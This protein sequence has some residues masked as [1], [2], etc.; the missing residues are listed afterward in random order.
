MNVLFKSVIT[1]PHCGFK[2]EETMPEDAC[3]YY[4]PCR[5]CKKML[6]PVA[7]DCCVF[8]SYGNVACPPEQ[9]KKLEQ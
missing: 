1:C 5:K 3:F 6:Q 4:Y 8:C 9:L 2:A 7:G